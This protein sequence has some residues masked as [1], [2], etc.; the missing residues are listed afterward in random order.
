MTRATSLVVRDPFSRRTA[1][2]TTTWPGTAWAGQVPRSVAQR[3][4]SAVLKDRALVSAQ[5]ME[6]CQGCSLPGLNA[7]A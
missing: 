7:T 4:A 6:R 5:L 2:S 3:L 1:A